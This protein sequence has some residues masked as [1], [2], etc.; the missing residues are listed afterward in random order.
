M[1]C[2]LTVTASIGTCAGTL[3]SELDWKALYRCADQALFQAKAAGRD[4]ARA[5]AAPAPP[6][7]TMALA[8]G[9]S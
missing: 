7:A 9:R 3:A 1:P 2:D 4:R 8:S 6:R 5:A